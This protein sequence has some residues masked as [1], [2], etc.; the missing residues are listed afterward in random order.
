MYM[1][2]ITFATL[3]AATV[4]AA[5]ACGGRSG[6]G[7]D[8]EGGAGNDVQ[9]TEIVSAVFSLSYSVSSDVLKIADV[10]V[11][12]TDAREIVHSEPLVSGSWSLKTE[13]EEF[14]ATV[15][16]RPVFTMKD[17]AV[18]GAKTYSVGDGYSV[19]I[20]MTDGNGKERIY[21]GGSPEGSIAIRADKAAAWVDA[22][23]G[24]AAHSCTVDASGTVDNGASSSGSGA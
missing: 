2:R 13:A 17:S 15:S 1:K 9:Q 3:L 11:E 20:T 22:Q 12:Y 21:S 14:P 23:N 18:Y 16:F 4:L 8:E 24:R 7:N 5:G 6:G 19:K 10:S